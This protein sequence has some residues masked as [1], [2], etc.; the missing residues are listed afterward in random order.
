MAPPPT[1]TLQTTPWLSY[2]TF[3]GFA[4]H[5]SQPET[6]VANGSLSSAEFIGQ[7]V[8]AEFCFIWRFGICAEKYCKILK[9]VLGGKIIRHLLETAVTETFQQNRTNKSQ[10][11][12]LN[13]A[14]FLSKS[15]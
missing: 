14:A 13:T 9:R 8:H 15:P 6:L 7:A 10:N 5:V 12:K 1:P 2:V 11:S 4:V 3:S